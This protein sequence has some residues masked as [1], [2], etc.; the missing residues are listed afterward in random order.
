M[1]AAPRRETS[2]LL[3]KYDPLL[4]G[5][6]RGTEG[7]A[8]GASASPAPARRPAGCSTTAAPCSSACS[9]RCGP[10][11]FWS[12]GSGRAPRWPTAGAASTTRTP[13][14]VGPQAVATALPTRPPLSTGSLPGEAA[15]PVC[16]LGP[17]DSPE[18]HHR[19][20]GALLLPEEP[21]PSHA[22]QLRA[23]ADDGEGPA[24][25]PSPPRPFLRSCSGQLRPLLLLGPTRHL[26]PQKG[27]R[28]PGLQGRGR[29]QGRARGL[30]CKP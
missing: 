23:G 10:C 19:R 24:T 9:W 14:W 21:H 11:C 12:A 22:G 13:R 5:G 28:V 30:G 7:P 3:P 25:L 27:P 2:H 20:G 17:H 26:L 16:R 29:A 15:A 4:K 8:V 1:S 18:P 6:N